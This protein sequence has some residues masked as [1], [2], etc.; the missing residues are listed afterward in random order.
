VSGEPVGRGRAPAVAARAGAL[1][2]ELHALEN[3]GLEVSAPVAQLD[4]A[5]RSAAVV[6]AV[7][8]RLARR[9]RRLVTRL[10]LAAPP[11]V[12]RLVVAHGAFVAGPLL[13]AAGALVALDFDRAC[14]AAPALDVA[15][16]AAGV[17][18]GRDDDLAS[19]RAVLEA[20][21]EGYGTRPLHLEWHL[22]VA[23]LLGAASPFRLQQED[24]PQRTAAIVQAA[25]AT[26][27]GA[28]R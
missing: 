3:P 28:A 20:T 16:F 18:S 10:E 26:L 9:V 5:R 6:G 14:L 24:W 17:A 23:L 25:E 2:R 8:P 19:V 13:E 22:A 11:A 15:T 21:A 1:L 4:A 7:A 12:P 27:D